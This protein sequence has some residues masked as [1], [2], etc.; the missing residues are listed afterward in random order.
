MLS[1]SLC[2][3]DSIKIYYHGPRVVSKVLEVETVRS[4]VVVSV[5]SAS[6]VQEADLVSGGVG[7]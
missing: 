6:Q 3:I 5:S 7:S 4:E 1:L 2:L